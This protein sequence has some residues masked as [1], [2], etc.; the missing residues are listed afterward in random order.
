M[1]ADRRAAHAVAAGGL[2]LAA[3]VAA[4]LCAT[5][6]APADPYATELGARLRGPSTG[7][8]LGRDSLGRD[9]LARVLH[10][11]RIS[12]A[13]G[14]ATVVLSL[15]V[16]VVLGAMAGWAGGIVDEGL[17]RVI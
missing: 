7:H 16:G 1:T 17:S 9:V 14:G 12:L 13:V 15:T 6:L 11:A 8:W 10:G 2:L 4:A 5:L 3:L